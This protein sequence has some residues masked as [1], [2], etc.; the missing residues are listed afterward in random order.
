MAR[1]A[2]VVVVAAA[3]AAA[4]VVVAVV[5]VDAAAAAVV[6]VVAAVVV[7]VYVLPTKT[8]QDPRAAARPASYTSNNREIAYFSMPIKGGRK[9]MPRSDFNLCGESSSEATKYT[10]I[11][12]IMRRF[13]EEPPRMSHETKSSILGAPACASLG[14]GQSRL[15]AEIDEKGHPFSHSEVKP[16]ALWQSIVEH[17]GIT[18]I[19][20]DLTP[21]SGA[22]AVAATGAAQYEGIAADG[23]HRD[24]FDSIVVERCVMYKAGHE[25][26]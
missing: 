5:V 1:S 15:Q 18:R 9:V 26:G 13:S 10:G 12:F 16:V 21:G 11:F 22:L 20:V 6:V 23:A 17:F 3:A 7:V 24:W 2:V 4:V 19:I 8:Q 25:Q 14:P